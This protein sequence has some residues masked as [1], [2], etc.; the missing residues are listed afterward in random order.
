MLQT[1]KS[2]L[3]VP[4]GAV[5]P[6]PFSGAVIV[7]GYKKDI[8]VSQD[9]RR[10]PYLSV[11][12]STPEKLMYVFL[13]LA[14]SLRGP[15]N[16]VLSEYDRN[17]NKLGEFWIRNVDN[18]VLRQKLHS[19]QEFVTSSGRLTIGILNANNNQE[20]QLDTHKSIFI[21]GSPL[22]HMEFLLEKYGIMQNQNMRFIDEFEHIHFVGEGYQEKLQELKTS[23]IS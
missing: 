4:T 13:E 23:L 5:M 20:V 19:H 22:E 14:S 7:E 17:E 9:Y 12:V 16:V 3:F 10:I 8:Y 2:A 21:F 1:S 18:T 6:K 15:L 11:N